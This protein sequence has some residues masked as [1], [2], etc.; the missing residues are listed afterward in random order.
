MELQERLAD[1]E[2]VEAFCV[3]AD[4]YHGPDSVEISA[5]TTR[6]EAFEE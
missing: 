2:A 3:L 1:A 5:R 4:I 6:P